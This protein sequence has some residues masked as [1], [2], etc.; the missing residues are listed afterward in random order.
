MARLMA[1]RYQLADA[2]QLHPYLHCLLL[3]DIPQQA[4]S[5]AICNSLTAEANSALHMGQSLLSLVTF[6]Y[7]GV[8]VGFD[9]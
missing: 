8:D 6:C 1:E 4:I 7:I 3:T 5:L 9:F 2:F